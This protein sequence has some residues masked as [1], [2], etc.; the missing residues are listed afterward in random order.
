MWFARDRH[1]DV[2]GGLV[3]YNLRVVV[4]GSGV[5]RNLDDVV[6]SSIPEDTCLFGYDSEVILWWVYRDCDD[7]GFESF[8]VVLLDPV[9]D[10]VPWDR[11]D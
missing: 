5:D 6:L 2:V 7:M 1:G 10:P 3:D 11:P 8:G 9:I 4:I